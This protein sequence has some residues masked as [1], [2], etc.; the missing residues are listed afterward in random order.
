MENSG[1]RWEGAAWLVYKRLITVKRAWW[2]QHQVTIHG[3]ASRSDI[4][5]GRYSATT[6]TPR[7]RMLPRSS[8]NGDTKYM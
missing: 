7:P 6:G 1:S 2:G 8:W 4:T 3:S 5:S